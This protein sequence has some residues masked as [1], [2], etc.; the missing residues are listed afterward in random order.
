MGETTKLV[1]D[2]WSK[3]VGVDIV[4]QIKKWSLSPSASKSAP[5]PYSFK[6]K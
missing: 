6:T 1:L 3:N 5:T 2:T 4:E